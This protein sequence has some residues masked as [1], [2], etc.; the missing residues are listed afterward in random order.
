MIKTESNREQDTV[1]KTVVES[2]DLVTFAP[3]VYFSRAPAPE[4]GYL[5]ATCRK[6]G[7]SRDKALRLAREKQLSILVGARKRFVFVA[8]VKAVAELMKERGK[9]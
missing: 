5:V 2:E 4:V 7:I 3:G 6:F 1:P 8:E 9:R